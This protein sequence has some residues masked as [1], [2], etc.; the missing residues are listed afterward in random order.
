MND[1]NEEDLV[2]IEQGATGCGAT[3]T[4]PVDD[5]VVP[6]A[7]E[8]DDEGRGDEENEDEAHVEDDEYVDL[9]VRNL[10]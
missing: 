5:L 3:S 8:S 6:N 2:N 10:L 1:P 9:R 4:Q 7:G